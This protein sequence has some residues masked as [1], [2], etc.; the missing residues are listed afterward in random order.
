M[1]LSGNTALGTQIQQYMPLSTGGT[2]TDIVTPTCTAVMVT[3]LDWFLHG[4]HKYYVS[5]KVTN[6]AGLFMIKSSGPYIHNVQLPAEGVV[7]DIEPHPVSCFIT[8]NTDIIAIFVKSTHRKNNAKFY[9]CD[10]QVVTFF[11][12]IRISQKF[13]NNSIYIITNLTGTTIFLCIQ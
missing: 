1:I 9:Y 5:I 8:L 7:F 4:N 13:L 2:C 12:L 10:P 11:T 3:T 6:T